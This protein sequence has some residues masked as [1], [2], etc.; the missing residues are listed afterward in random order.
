MCDDR[1]ATVTATGA[2]D[3][4]GTSGLDEGFGNGRTA[5]HA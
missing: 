5:G 3:L 4:V 2:S 1:R